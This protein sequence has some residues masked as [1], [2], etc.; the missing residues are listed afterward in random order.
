M[1]TVFRA[2][3]SDSHFKHLHSFRRHLEQCEEDG[4]LRSPRVKSCHCRRVAG[5]AVGRCATTDPRRLPPTPPPSRASPPPASLSAFCQ[6]LENSVETLV[7]VL[8]RRSECW[9]R[10][11]VTMLCHGA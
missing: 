1:H 6:S 10:F 4:L 7:D 11:G 2:Q 3:F 5:G 8:T 9:R